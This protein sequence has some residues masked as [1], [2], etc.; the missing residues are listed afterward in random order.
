MLELVDGPTLADRIGR[1]PIPLDEARSIARQIAEALEAAH[2]QGIIHRDLKPANIKIR[3]DGTVKVLDFGLAKALES[4]EAYPERSLAPTITSPAM[5][6]AGVLLGTAP[7]M[8][9]ELAKGRPADRRS[10]IWAFG[11]VLYEMLSGR[12]AFDGDHMTEVLGAVVRLEPDWSALPANVPPAVRSV[13]KRCLQKDPA[14]RMRDIADARF[15]VEEAFDTPSGSVQSVRPTLGRGGYAGWVVAALVTTVATALV[16]SD[17]SSA[18]LP[19][20]RLEI[21]TPPAVDPLSLAMSPDGRSVV[22]QGELESPRLWLRSLA[23]PEARALTGT[24]GATMPFWSPDNRSIGFFANGALKRIDLESGFVRTVAPAPDPRGG[25]WHTDGTILIGGGLGPLNAVPANGGAVKQGT[26]LLPGQTN[27]RWP[28]FLPGGDRFLLF[29]TGA[30]D[31]RGLYVGSLTDT[32]LHRVS[33][34]ESAYTFLPPAYVL[35]ARQGAL[36]ALRLNREYV[37]AAGALI[38]VAP[39]TLVHGALVGYGAFSSSATGSIAYRASAKKTQLLWLNRTGTTVG[40]LGQPDDSQL[41]LMQ[42]SSDGRTV[43]VERNVDGNRDVW[44]IDVARGVHRRLTFDEGDDGAPIFSPDGSRVVHATG[45]NREFFEMQERR[46][47]GTKG[48]MLVLASDDDYKQPQDWTS[49]G[50]YILYRVQTMENADL[51]ALPLF[52][53]RKPI[54]VARTSF[55]ESNGRFSP[56][57]RWVAYESTETGRSEIYV[58]PFPGPGPKS[59]ISVGGGILPRWRRDGSELFYVAADRHLMSVSVTADSARLPGSVPRSL[60]RL[61]SLLYEPSPDGQRFLVNTVVSEASPITI[62]L[63]WKAPGRQER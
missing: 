8:S 24:E 61:P 45:G 31:V 1:G 54:E 11:C 53:E 23:S 40:A 35:L 27:H 50:R 13:L 29:A 46:S 42:L 18:E 43:A 26:P 28:Q 21:V 59:Q 33:D 17:W 20:T 37:S 6:Q 2:E 9:P 49:D 60:F 30:P 51:W 48:Q 58:Q 5:T 41:L 36:W 57:G 47:D 44:L 19:E 52:G 12:R 16:L 38:P 63:N 22:F 34:R 62:I 14:L 56:N 3:S 10:D 15:Q 7:Y 25:S 32:S 39:K 55:A 4:L